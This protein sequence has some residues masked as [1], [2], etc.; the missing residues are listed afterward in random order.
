MIWR[1]ENFFPVACRALRRESR[2][3][4]RTI[5]LGSVLVL[6][7]C[8]TSSKSGEGSLFEVREASREPRMSWTEMPKD[9]EEAPVYVSDRVLLDADDVSKA[10]AKL[11]SHGWEIGIR[12]TGQGAAKFAG[13]TESL[14]GK[15]MAI[16]VDGEVVSTPVSQGRIYSGAII[17]TGNLDEK[18]A[19]K[20]ARALSR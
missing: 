9:G 19:K 13:V 14:Y 5:L 3:M 10:E 8:L 7:G 16:I 2:S 12:L 15:M 11:G 6:S 17:I 18:S 1:L 4:L 20:V